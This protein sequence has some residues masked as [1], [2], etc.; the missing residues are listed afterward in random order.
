MAERS[1]F[2]LEIGTEELPPKALRKLSE[3]LRDHLGNELEQLQLNFDSIRALASPRRLAVLVS[4]L[5]TEQPD[6]TEDRRGPAIAS[7]F[8]SEGNPTKAA[9]GFARSCATTVAELDR[10]VTD[11]GEWLLARLHQPGQTAVDLLP[12]AVRLAVAKLPVPKLMRW[13]DGDV[14]FVRPVHWVVMLLGRDVVG[15]EVLGHAADRVTRGHRFLHPG[16][17]SLDQAGDYTAQLRQASVMV[18]TDERIQTIR[19]QIEKLAQELG[20]EAV[21][22]AALLEEVAGLIEWPVAIVGAIEHRYLALPPEVIISTIQGHQKYFAI[23]DPKNGGLMPYFVTVSNLVSRDPV[24]VKAGNE[25]VVRPRLADAEFFYREDLKTPLKDR[26]SALGGVVFQDRLG[27]MADRVERLERLAARIGEA[28]GADI[29]AVRQ[30]SQLAKA[31]L[32]SGMVNEFPELQGVMGS[33]Y[34]RA[35]GYSSKVA[36]PIREH[37]LPRFAGDALPADP[38]SQALALADRLDLLC[39]IFA[40]GQRP[41]GERDPFGLRR[42]AIGLL[43]IAIEAEQDV[44]FVP[45]IKAAAD[46]QP[47]S[48]DPETRNAVFDFIFER[49]RVHY[50]EQD[51]P[52]DVIS[53]VMARRPGSPLDFDRRLRALLNFRQSSSWEALAAANKRIHNILKQAEPNNTPTDPD[54]F[55]E[56]AE[57]A[58]FSAM[59]NIAPEVES[60]LFQR[61]YSRAMF[62]LAHLREPVDRFFDE[63]MVMADDPAVRANRLSLLA[64]MREMFLGVADLSCLQNSA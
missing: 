50:L 43:R 46:A 35:Q 8:D 9:E 58:V 45:L 11:K 19:A 17:V 16:S 57:K 55:E 34:A 13:G 42:A 4:G 28:L 31:D 21:L 7:A 60:A 36:T 12:E 59:S 63:V 38:E 26:A 23:R 10:L 53:A 22:D 54:R 25:R 44:D 48:T 15:G 6:R 47:V 30:A 62:H 49:L 3:A 64:Q 32:L 33:Y 14:S 39:G 51:I 40:L 18:D 5:E 37:Y 24:Q 29:E 52:H 56:D 1:E 27:S 2:L 61:D 41:T 20:G